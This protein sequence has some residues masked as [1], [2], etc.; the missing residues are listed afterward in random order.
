[1]QNYKNEF[2]IAAAVRGA[3]SRTFAAQARLPIGA[4]QS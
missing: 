3:K 4:I 1:M 2:K